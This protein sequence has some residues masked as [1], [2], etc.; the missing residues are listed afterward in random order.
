[1]L[2]QNP[3]YG[4]TMMFNRPLIE[5]IKVIPSEAENHDFW[6]ALVASALG[7]ISYLNKITI[8]YRQ[9]DN[10]I[11]TNHDNSSLAKRFDRIVLRREIFSD[12]DAKMKM[13]VA[14]KSIYF[15]HLSDKNK[16][17]INDFISLLKNF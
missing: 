8:L 7:K 13:A 15:R 10:N 16:M 17:I 14:F 12:I 3:A 9:H 2:A 11:S 1:L 5:T 6:V 4:C